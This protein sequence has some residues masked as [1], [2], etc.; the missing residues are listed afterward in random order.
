MSRSDLSASIPIADLWYSRDAGQWANALE[1]YWL[2]IRPENIQLERA[3]DPLDIDELRRL[4]PEGWYQF[5]REK[6]FRW[7]YTAPNRYATTTHALDRNARKQGGLAALVAVRD[8][9]LAV[10]SEDVAGAVLV[11]MKIPGLG[12]AGASGLL[13]LLYPRA[14]GTVDQFV[15]KALR[16]IPD[17]PE[18][19]SVA[20]MNP[21]ALLPGDAVV[22]IGAMRRQAAALA[23]ALRTD[24]WT[25]RAIDK[26]LWTYGR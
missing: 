12:T 15:V 9:L 2:F 21:E 16:S 18:A 24:I 20:A 23:A 22:L 26:V 6:Y 13:A 7:K 1:R 5:L 19:G 8:Q 11:A 14:F 4:D 25:P 10:K 3:I 17:L